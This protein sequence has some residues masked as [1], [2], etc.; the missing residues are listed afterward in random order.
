[1]TRGRPRNF[2][3]TQA[4]DTALHL[5]WRHG[6]EGTSI[7]LLAEAIGVNPPSLYAAFGNK[8]DLF[9]QAIERYAEV[10]GHIYHDALKKETVRE[11]VESILAGEVELIT[12]RGSPNGCLMIQGALVASPESEKICQMMAKMRGMA[13][14]WIAKR[15]EQAKTEGD[16]PADCDCR[17]LAC[18]LMTL[19]SGLAVQAK[20]GVSKKQLLKVVDLI[21]ESWPVPGKKIPSSTST[22]RQAS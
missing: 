19:N 18:Y 7:A 17:A 5:F 3:K 11:V 22:V 20:S 16:L 8:E 9:L 4:L 1:M 10:N 2:D 15:F 12:R 13:E 14:G 6:Y 21:L